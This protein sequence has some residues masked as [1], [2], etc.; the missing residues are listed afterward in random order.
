MAISNPTETCDGKC[1][2]FGNLSSRSTNL[3]PSIPGG[4]VK[5][6]TLTGWIL[7]VLNT[8][9]QSYSVSRSI[10]NFIA[11]DENVFGSVSKLMYPSG[12]FS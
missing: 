8:A 4:W 12:L 5:F 7:S 2:V 3:R 6:S 10:A 11:M 9:L 1:T